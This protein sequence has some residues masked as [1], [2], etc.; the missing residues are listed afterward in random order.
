MNSQK[1]ILGSL[2]GGLAYFLLGYL[3]Y[4]LLLKDFFA[5]NAGSATGVMRGAD[6]LVWW[7]LILGDL[8]MGCL[9]ASVFGKA[10]ITSAGT[11]AT[12]G[13]VIGLLFSLAIRLIMYGTTNMMTLKSVAAG[14]VVSAVIS[15][16]AGAVVGL[17]LGMSKKTVAAA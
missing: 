16:I 6:E 15:T 5:N 12:W 3:C 8:F 2:A 7:A 13:F 17:V 10:G 11:G 4:G 9:L 14:I 1:L